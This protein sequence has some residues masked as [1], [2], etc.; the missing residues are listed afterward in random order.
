MSKI[1]CFYNCGAANLT[2]KNIEEHYLKHHT[3]LKPYYRYQDFQCDSCLNYFSRSLLYSPARSQEELT[4]SPHYC[5]QCAN[6]SKSIQTN[7]KLRKSM[8][9]SPKKIKSKLKP[10]KALK[11]RKTLK[12]KKTQSTALTLTKS[13]SKVKNTPAY[14]N[15]LLNQAK[16]GFKGK[17]TKACSECRTKA[18]ALNLAFKKEAQKLVQS[19][20]QLGVS[21]SK[22]LSH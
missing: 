13:R 18:P 6:Q 14:Y 21:L 7:L 9:K 15:C 4:T 19:Y 3:K 16:S 11:S 12:S 17:I 10:R 20:K 2:L 5:P 1:A 8:K 22:I